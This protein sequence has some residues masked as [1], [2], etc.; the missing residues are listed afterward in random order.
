M[1]AQIKEAADRIKF[2][3]RGPGVKDKGSIAAQEKLGRDTKLL[4]DELARLEKDVAPVQAEIAELDGLLEPYNEVKKRLSAARATMRG[5]KAKLLDRLDEARQRLSA[6]DD[7]RIVLAMISEDIVG[8]LE[9]YVKKHRQEVVAV[10]ENWW[11]KYHT[12]FHSIESDR[13][14]AAS[15]FNGLV[16][17]V[18]YAK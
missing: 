9:C 8:Q 4:R 17:G 15:G 3:T 11:D 18:G 5:L 1:K 14:V 7:Q 12:D 6:Q 16:T 2:L 10:V 13:T